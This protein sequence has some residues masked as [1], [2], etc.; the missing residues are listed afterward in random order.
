MRYRRLPAVRAAVRAAA[1]RRS[2]RILRSIRIRRRTAVLAG[3][4]AGLAAVALL[5]VGPQAAME[6]L[7]RQAA[8]LP[9][10][11]VAPA[12]PGPGHPV[13]VVAPT[14]VLA[15][16]ASLEVKGRAPRT[17][18]DRLEFGVAWEDTNRNGCDTRNDVLRRDL[19]R[20]VLDPAGCLVVTGRLEDPYT[21]RAIEF[22]RGGD[23]SKEVQIDHV[24]ALGD[25]WQKGAQQ[26]DAQ[27]RSSLANDP[28]NLLAVDGPTNEEKSDGDAATWLP[29]NAGFRC[30][31]IARQIS[32]KA[33]Y[34]LWVTAA[35]KEA[36][37]RILAGC[38]VQQ[39]LSSG[40]F[41][42]G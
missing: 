16:L 35:E 14:N 8:A 27:Q 20:T 15:V 17:G 29:P 37:L 22:R 23:S 19:T 13:L 6:S 3:A 33:A 25:A 21:G 41:P 24:V 40:Y 1:E 4:L 39:S 31:Y 30:Q 28:L 34:R 26:L 10:P 11:V 42:G 38:P 18:Y 12:P 7:A 2:I 5:A 36:M 32:V 9:A